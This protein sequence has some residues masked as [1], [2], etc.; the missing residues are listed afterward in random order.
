MVIIEVFSNPPMPGRTPGL[1]DSNE[2]EP[3]PIII[4]GD[5]GPVDFRKFVIT[6]SVNN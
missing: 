4:Q 6:P 2:G 3:G 5:H 1:L